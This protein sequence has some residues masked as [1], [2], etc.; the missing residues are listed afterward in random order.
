MKLKIFGNK[1]LSQLL[2]YVVRITTIGYLISLLF[3][4]FSLISHISMTVSDQQFQIKIPMTDFVI[5]GNYDLRTM[6]AITV[7][8]IFYTVFFYVLSMVLKTFKEEILFTKTAIKYLM[9]FTILNLFFPVLY[10]ILQVII[11]KRIDFNDL[12]IA[13]LHIILGIFSMF[14]IAIFKQ[15]VQ[16]QEETELTI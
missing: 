6:I 4:V 11:S 13:F 16:L 9:Y 1:S 15:G 7:F 3:I 8:F 14:I 5:K 2:F 12:S 10:G